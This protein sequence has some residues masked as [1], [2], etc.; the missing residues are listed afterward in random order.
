M[1]QGFAHLRPGGMMF[2]SGVP[3]DGLAFYAGYRLRP[4]ALPACA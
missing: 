1:K 3:D 4:T 2:L